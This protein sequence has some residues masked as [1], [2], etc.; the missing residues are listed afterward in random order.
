MKD[1]P[2]GFVSE[3]VLEEEEE[4]E[5]VPVDDVPDAEDVASCGAAST[6]ANGFG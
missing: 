3:D 6:F 1:C 4:E 2:A 5:E